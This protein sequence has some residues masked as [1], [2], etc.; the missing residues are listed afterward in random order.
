MRTTLTLDDDVTAKLTEKVRATGKSFKD[1]VNETLRSGFFSDEKRATLEPF[2]IKEEHLL[3]GMRRMNY[4]KV[5]LVFD[6][7]D[8]PGRLR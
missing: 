3:H 8:G 1:V 5:E 2:V 7:L 4:D 6:E